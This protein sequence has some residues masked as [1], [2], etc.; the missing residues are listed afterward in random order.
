[1]TKTIE[2]KAYNT[3]DCLDNDCDVLESAFEGH[4]SD[5]Y[6][7]DVISSEADSAVSIY[8]GDLWENAPKISDYIEEAL[9]SGLVDTSAGVDLMKIFTA[10]E[11]EYYSSLLNQNI[12]ELSFNYVAKQVN[13]YL[14]KLDESEIEKVDIEELTE[15]INDATTNFDNNN[16]LDELDDIVAEVEDMIETMIEK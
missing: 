3:L 6:I 13:E 1:M 11:N 9:E 14:V 15:Y 16:T 7:C 8:N 12:D 4:S 2:M 10:G 5:E